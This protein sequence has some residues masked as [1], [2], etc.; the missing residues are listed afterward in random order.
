MIFDHNR[1]SREVDGESPKTMLSNWA[2]EVGARTTVGFQ[3]IGSSRGVL[4]EV[5]G[6]HHQKI[7]VIDDRVIL[8]GANLS[9]N[10]FLNRKDRALLIDSPALSDYLFE[11][12]RIL[13]TN[14]G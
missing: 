4:S 3:K 13:A 7:Y 5:A 14:P 11:Y 9:K 8:S 2:E 10:Y 12:I 1:S 6:V